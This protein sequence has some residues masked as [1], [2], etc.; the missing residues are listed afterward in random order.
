MRLMLVLENVDAWMAENP[1]MLAV[2]GA[3]AAQSTPAG[4]VLGD[5][6]VINEHNAPTCTIVWELNEG[7]NPNAG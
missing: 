5:C 7:G 1:T 6:H 2:F 3:K 4:Y